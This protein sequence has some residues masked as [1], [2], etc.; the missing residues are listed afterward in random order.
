MSEE[1]RGDRWHQAIGI[2]SVVAQRGLSCDEEILCAGTWVTDATASLCLT[3]V[4]GACAFFFYLGRGKISILFRTLA[5]RLCLE[6][7]NM[8]TY[9]RLDEQFS[10]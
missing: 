1:I 6:K 2:F 9:T 5:I 8:R 10:L 3:N 7:S 4:S